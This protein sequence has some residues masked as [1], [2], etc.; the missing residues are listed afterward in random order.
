[1]AR[2]TSGRCQH[3][4]LDRECLSEDLLQGRL[5]ECSGSKSKSEIGGFDDL[6]LN[7]RAASS[8]S[9]PEKG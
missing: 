6:G 7:G 3:M 5:K 4:L 8:A 2:E 1:M 9:Q